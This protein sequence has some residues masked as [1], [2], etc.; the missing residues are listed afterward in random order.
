MLLCLCKLCHEQKHR[1]AANSYPK[2]IP[3]KPSLGSYRYVIVKYVIHG[4]CDEQYFR[5]VWRGALNPSPGVANVVIFIWDIHI[6]LGLPYY[7]KLKTANFYIILLSSR[8]LIQIAGK[9]INLKTFSM[10]GSKSSWGFIHIAVK[11]INNYWGPQ[12]WKI[13]YSERGTPFPCHKVN[14]SMYE[15]SFSMLATLL[16]FKA[17][18]VSSN[19]WILS[20]DTI[21]IISLKL[22]KTLKT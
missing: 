3:G 10:Y 20:M 12:F 19:R 16:V 17:C 1:C 8:D 4:S 22:S 14:K 13:M 6:L 18:L 21:F 9:C 7:T 15:I 5:C 2:F 11:C